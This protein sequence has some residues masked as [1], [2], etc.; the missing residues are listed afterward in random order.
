MEEGG[1]EMGMTN[2]G[3]TYI[4]HN[5]TLALLL[6]GGVAIAVCFTAQFG[7]IKHATPGLRT[8]KGETI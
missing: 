4:Y 6:Q 8:I 3:D 5:F 2:P 7:G 1:T